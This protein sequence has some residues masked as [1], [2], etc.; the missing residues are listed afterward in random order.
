MIKGLADWIEANSAFVV[1]TTLQVAQRAQDAPDRCAVIV[2][3]AGGETNFYTHDL[4]WMQIQVVTRGEKG[5]SFNARDDA[6]VLFNLLHGAAG[7]EFGTSPDIFCATVTAVNPPQSIGED[8]RR[9][10]EFSTN[11]RF[12]I[13][14]KNGI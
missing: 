5:N 3:N 10:P 6:Y 9:R 2:E 1:G 13:Y 12:A 11:Y 14:K 8:D 7:I 4:M